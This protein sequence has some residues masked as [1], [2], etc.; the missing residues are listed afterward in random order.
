MLTVDVISSAADLPTRGGARE[1]MRSR[2]L[3]PLKYVES[4][5]VPFLWGEGVGPLFYRLRGGLATRLTGLKF[6]P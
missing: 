3:E 1:A 6:G 4:L 5:P 2:V